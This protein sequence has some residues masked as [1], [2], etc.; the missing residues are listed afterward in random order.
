MIK[1]HG[2]LTHTAIPKR[3]PVL[4]QMTTRPRPVPSGCIDTTP[5]DLWDVLWETDPEGKLSMPTFVR[6]KNG[7][8]LRFWKAYFSGSDDQHRPK[9][10]TKFWQTY[11]KIYPCGHPEDPTPRKYIPSEDW[12]ESKHG[13]FHSNGKLVYKHPDGTIYSH[14]VTGV[15][16][17]H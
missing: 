11:W 12:D 14:G 5:V 9:L 3:V 10:P 2:L 16:H 7:Q 17:F 6:L 4:S 8:I 15:D 1:K 13:Y